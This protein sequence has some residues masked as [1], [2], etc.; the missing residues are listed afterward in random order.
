PYT[1]LFRSPAGPRGGA[2]RGHQ[3]RA[4]EGNPGQ[5]GAPADYRRGDGRCRAESRR[6]GE[7]AGVMAIW[8]DK[9][10]R[11]IVQ[12]V[13]GRE[14]TFHAIQCR[15]YGTKVVGG[16]TPGKGGTTP[17][18]LAVFNTVAEARDKEGPTAR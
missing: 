4:G 7:G 6:R 3:R 15:D 18:G 17:E 5:V 16:V 11:V 10:T 12:G 1:T 8:A 13:T 2:A 9:N 14:G